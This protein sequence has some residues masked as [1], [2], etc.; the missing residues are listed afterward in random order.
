VEL[1]YEVPE[2]CPICESPGPFPLS[3]NVKKIRILGGQVTYVR[4]ARCGGEFHGNM[5]T[6]ETM[7]EWYS[8]GTYV[9]AA[10]DGLSPERAQCAAT[11]RVAI[12]QAL[13]IKVLPRFLEFGSGEGYLLREVKRVYNSEVVGIEKDPNRRQAMAG[14]NDPEGQFNVIAAMHS[15]E[16]V[17]K[18][19]EVLR[20]LMTILAP[21]G[22]VLIEV[23]VTGMKYCESHCIAFTQDS[24]GIMT[25][26]A[27]L[28]MIAEMTP[29]LVG[30]MFAVF[31]RDGEA[32]SGQAD[33]ED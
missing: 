4:C 10:G 14:T 17:N 19:L 32:Q 7:D 5:W 20:W 16:H 11:R 33:Q 27:G 25:K 18:P 24:L 8:S 15:L 23:P 3:G 30:A 28:K 12:M 21:G 22:L 2:V 6:P 29:V 31:G 13:G 26:L 1:Q 9:K